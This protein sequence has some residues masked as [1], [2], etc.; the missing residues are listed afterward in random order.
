MK[1]L[2]EMGRVALGL[3]IVLGIDVVGVVLVRLLRPEQDIPTLARFGELLAVGL[4][5]YLGGQVTT[6]T[7]PAPVAGPAPVPVRPA[8]APGGM[9]DLDV[10][11][12]ADV[13]LSSLGVPLPTDASGAV[14]HTGGT[15]DARHVAGLAANAG[16]QIT[17][18]ASDVEQ[19]RAGLFGKAD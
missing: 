14:V 15:S 11:A 2:S 12:Q 19:L 10:R 13:P 16:Q 18:L 17:P 3:V 5:G 1:N 7:T 9:S 8:E 4:I 6:R